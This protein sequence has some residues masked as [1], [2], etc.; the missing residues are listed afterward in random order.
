MV[1]A[2]DFDRKMLL[3][4]TQLAH[5]SDLKKVLLVS[6]EALLSTL[7]SHGPMDTDIEAV[8]LVR[9]IIRLVIRL[10][11]ETANEKDRYL[12]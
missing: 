10:M 8:C 11:K 7:R 5:E 4:A 3:V 6:L 2:A 9:C 12:C 1:K